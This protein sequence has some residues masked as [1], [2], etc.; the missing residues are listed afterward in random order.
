MSEEEKEVYE[1][2]ASMPIDLKRVNLLRDITFE[3]QLL[4]RSRFIKKIHIS[5]NEFTSLPE[6]SSDKEILL[7]AELDSKRFILYLANGKLVSIAMSDPDK[8]ERVVGLKP[9]AMLIMAS[10]L[11]PIVFK[12]FEIQPYVEE[13]RTQE[14]P[15]EVKRELVEKKIP[16]THIIERTR[17]PREKG[18]PIVIK[19]AEKLADFYK[20]ARKMVE[21]TAPTYGCQLV[22]LKIGVS[23][24]VLNINVIVK[25]KGLFGKCRSEDLG[26][27]LE[28]DLGLLLAMVDLNLPIKVQV[29]VTK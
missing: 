15:H 29:S 24:G 27:V 11:Q 3:A 17:A 28:N 20:K 25:K 10:K 8:G 12:L 26:K 9:L 13:D 4:M 18:K 5:Y 1:L 2:I 14:T 22:D 21:D 7:T 16:P 23:R 19:F 6:I